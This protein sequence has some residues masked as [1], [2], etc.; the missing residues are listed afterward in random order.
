MISLIPR[1][2]LGMRLLHDMSGMNHKVENMVV[3]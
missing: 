3:Q 1:S 2:G